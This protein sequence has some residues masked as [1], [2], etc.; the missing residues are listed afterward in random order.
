[1]LV[2]GLRSATWSGAA[3]AHGNDRFEML[4]Q[5]LTNCYPARVKDSGRTESFSVH[6]HSQVRDP[7]CFPDCSFQRD[8]TA[9]R[10]AEEC[11]G[12]ECLPA[13]SMLFA[14]YVAASWQYNSPFLI[15]CKR[16]QIKKKNKKK[17]DHWIEE[18][19]PGKNAP[20]GY[21]LMW[22]ELPC[23][24]LMQPRLPW[25]VQHQISSVCGDDCTSVPVHS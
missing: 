15:C 12:Y 2:S 1:M 22:P 13:P 17:K 23:L 18:Y 20:E 25:T 14:G 5:A 7:D 9:V 24:D 4:S 6:S 19:G 8:T 10:A 16:S 3:A 21:V 11:T